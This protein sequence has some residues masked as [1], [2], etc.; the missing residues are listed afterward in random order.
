[1]IRKEFVTPHVL[2]AAIIGAILWDLATWRVGL[3]TSSSHAIIGGLCGYSDAAS[4]GFCMADRPVSSRLK[5]KAGSIV[6]PED[7]AG[8]E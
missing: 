7:P 8:I 6:S 1:M 5:R 2:L 4:R 3:P